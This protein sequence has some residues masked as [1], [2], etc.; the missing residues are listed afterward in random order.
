MGHF[1]DRYIISKYV[2]IP[3]VLHERTERFLAHY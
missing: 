3:L 1:Q 2:L